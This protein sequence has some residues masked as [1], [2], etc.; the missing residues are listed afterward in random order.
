[1]ETVKGQWLPG[2]VEGVVHGANRQSSEDFRA[3]NLLC[4]I[5]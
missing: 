2:L 4:T 3:G 1:M 5:L